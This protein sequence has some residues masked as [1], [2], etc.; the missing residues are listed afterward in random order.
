MAALGLHCWMWAFSRCRDYSSLRCAGFSLRVA[1]L[2]AEHGPWA[3][4]SSVV[5]AHRLSYPT[6]CGILPNQER[7]MSPASAGEFLN[8][9]PLWKSHLQVDS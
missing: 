8:T 5:A 9:R 1:S 7:N 3:P 2:A 6:A 4:Q